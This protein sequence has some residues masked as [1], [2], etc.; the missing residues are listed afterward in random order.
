MVCPFIN[1]DE[2]KCAENLKL[3]TI[4]YA[5]AVCGDE[6]TRCEVFWRMMSRTRDESAAKR[7]SVA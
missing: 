6:F 1:G 4:D 3:D 5:V 2:K 7:A